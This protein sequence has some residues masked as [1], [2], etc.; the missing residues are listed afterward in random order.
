MSGAGAVLAA[1]D[2]IALLGLEQHPEGGWYAQTY[3][4]TVAGGRA[5]STL[6]YY[7]LEAGEQSAWHRVDAAEVWHWYSGAPLRLRVAEH[8]P[9]TDLT[10]GNDLAAGQRPQGIV[11]PGAWQSARSLGAWTLV[12]CTVA[13]GF[14]FER[15]ERAPKGW[16]PG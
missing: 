13:P 15:F 4:D 2:V 10:L 7:L 12:G 3:A 11:P 5:Y 9:A 8:G 6:I 16:E 14:E 1:S